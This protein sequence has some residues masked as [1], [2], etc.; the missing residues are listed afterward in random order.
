MFP[1]P[2]HTSTH[3]LVLAWHQAERSSESTVFAG[4][5]QQGM[6]VLKLLLVWAD[7]KPTNAEAAMTR[8][9]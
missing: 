5:L 4:T 6:G 3:V 7:A 8:V 9:E 2:P 1:C